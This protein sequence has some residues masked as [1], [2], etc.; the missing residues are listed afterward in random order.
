ME[1]DRDNLQCDSSCITHFSADIDKK[2]A[3]KH[4]KEKIVARGDLPNASV[5]KQLEIFLEKNNLYP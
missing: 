3:L 5:N 4:I 1:N 2:N